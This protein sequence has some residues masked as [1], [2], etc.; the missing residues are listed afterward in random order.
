MAPASHRRADEDVEDEDE[1]AKENRRRRSP[2]AVPLGYTAPSL[3]LALL[4]HAQE[5]SSSRTATWMKVVIFF[6]VFEV[7]EVFEVF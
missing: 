4:L 3:A 6:D 7:F 1:E 5:G 2:S